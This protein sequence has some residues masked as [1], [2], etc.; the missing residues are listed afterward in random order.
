MSLGATR[1]K[2]PGM[3]LL[4]FGE[5]LG[6]VHIGPR[7]AAVQAS[8]SLHEPEHRSRPHEHASPY[9]CVVL[10][11][12]FVEGEHQRRGGEMIVHPSGARHVDRIG[13]EGA[14]CLNL[15]LGDEPARPSAA[16]V[17]L[18]RRRLAEALAAELVLGADTLTAASLAHE[19]AEGALTI[20]HERSDPACVR[21]LLQALDDQ[22]EADWTLAALAKLA[23]RHPAHAARQFR[24]AIGMTLGGWRRRRRATRAGLDLRTGT[25]SLAEIA[26]RHGYADQAHM[27]RDLRALAGRTPRELRVLGR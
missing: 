7:D 19:L 8:L 14:L 20:P 3:T 5:N 13:V 23:D 11:G 25:A 6:R 21:R 10:G 1:R 4:A 16:R 22:P 12:G 27:T 9:I 15:H 26:S 17:D 18:E 2:E 24:R